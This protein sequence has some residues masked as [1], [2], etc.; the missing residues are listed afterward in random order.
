MEGSVKDTFW[1]CGEMLDCL[2]VYSFLG[3]GFVWG[4]IFAVVSSME[5][6]KVV[7]TIDDGFHHLARSS[8]VA[9]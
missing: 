8:R 3:L 4:S 7:C 9:M 2:D 5:G 1:Y 6:D